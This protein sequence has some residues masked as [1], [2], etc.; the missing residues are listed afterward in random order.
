LVSP[1]FP[2]QPAIDPQSL[3]GQWEG[4]WLVQTVRGPRGGRY[5]LTLQR[6]ENDVLYGRVEFTGSLTPQYDVHG[7]VEGN[8]LTYVS[9][10]KQVTAKLTIA[11]DTMSGT[12]S[13]ELGVT[14]TVAMT[15]KK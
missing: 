7:T 3:I 5:Y 10:D 14:V 4:D 9:A 12:S 2:Q 6:V 13:R 8:V 1:S 15:R 11:G